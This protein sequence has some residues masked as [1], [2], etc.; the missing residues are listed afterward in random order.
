[1]GESLL[2]AKIAG[3]LR[4]LQ[5]SYGHA[6][7]GDAA[8]LR[9][10]IGAAR[11][12][13]R[14]D[15]AT[16]GDGARGHDAILFIPLTILGR[17]EPAADERLRNR[18]RDDLNTC[19]SSIRAEHIASVAFEPP[20]ESDIEFQRSQALSTAPQTAPDAVP[21]WQP[22]QIRLFISHRDTHKEAARSLGDALSNFGITAFVAHDTIEAMT[23]WRDE[24]RKGLD[25]MEVMLAFVTDDF[26]ESAWTHQ[27]IGF[28]LGRGVPVIAV[29]LQ[30][31]TPSGFL[32]ATQAVRGRLDQA[33]FAAPQIY[34][35]LAQKLGNKAR[36]QAGLVQAFVQSPSWAETR[37]R[38]DRL[39]DS[40]DRLTAQEVQEIIR[41]FDENDQLHFASYLTN[42]ANRLLNF[43]ERTTER[44]FE[45]ASKR[46]YIR[47]CPPA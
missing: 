43:L 33:M 8:L 46:P 22:G 38:F 17:I 4:R 45:Y 3:Y 2:R 18:L 11:F 42:D 39:D 34:R 35:L 10:L 40:V 36:L 20:D 25:T 19:G 12:Y 23:T 7:S 37:I 5:I 24:V 31:K 28:A 27:E 6:S 44:E 13:L 14:E 15:T 16:G 41:G 32:E 1:V 21:F 26:D 9:D 30:R 29:Q 47:Q